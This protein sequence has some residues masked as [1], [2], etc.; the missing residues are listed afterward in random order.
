MRCFF[1]Y[2]K[3]HSAGRL[4]RRFKSNDSITE[5]LNQ[6]VWIYEQALVISTTRGLVVVSG[7][8]HP[9]IVEIVTRARE[10]MA[11]PVHLVMGGFHLAGTSASEVR[12]IIADFHRLGV[13]L[14]AP[15]HCTGEAAMAMFAADYGED[16]VQA[17]VGRVL[18]ID[19]ADHNG[20][21]H[22]TESYEA[23]EAFLAGAFGP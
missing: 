7:C 13:E 14:A 21:V 10:M 18:L 22:S 16:Y 23:V 1:Q 11:G 3:L 8:A 20:I 5:A 9:G 17:G 2:A 6:D 15:T 19:G 12:A 4:P